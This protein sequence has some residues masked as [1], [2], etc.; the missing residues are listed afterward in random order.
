MKKALSGILAFSLILA[1]SACGGKKAAFSPAKDAARLR[2]TQGVFTTGLTQ[3]DQAAACALYGIDEST[4]TASAV[5]GSTSSAEELAI[6]TFSSQ[7]EA[8]AAQPLLQYR[9]EDRTEELRDY[10]PD[11]LPKLEKAIIE[12]REDSVLLVVA[13]DYGPVEDFLKG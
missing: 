11:E 6:F 10:L 2:D 3:I 8:Q 13:S 7:E 4:V 5:F 9:V 12:V 1:L